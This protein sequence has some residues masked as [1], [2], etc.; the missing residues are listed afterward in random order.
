MHCFHHLCDE[1]AQVMAWWYCGCH[2]DPFWW[3]YVTEIITIKK[4][5]DVI[6]LLCFSRPW[7]F[8]KRFNYFLFYSCWLTKESEPVLSS[9]FTQREKDGFMPF[10]VALAWSETQ[11]A[12][13]GTFFLMITVMHIFT[14]EKE[15]ERERERE[16]N[17]YSWAC[18]CVCTCTYKEITF[19][20]FFYL[21]TVKTQRIIIQQP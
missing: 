20:L 19:Y 10:S 4:T 11:T 16:S 5:C 6:V 7:C 12:S 3:R 9:C 14:R 8:A 18:H 15:R 17:A 1:M 13:S 21:S 2:Y